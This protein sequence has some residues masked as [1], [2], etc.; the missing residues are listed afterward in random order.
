MHREDFRIFQ[1]EESFYEEFESQVESR[2]VDYIVAVVQDEIESAQALYLRPEEYLQN[3]LSELPTRARLAKLNNESVTI[4]YLSALEQLEHDNPEF[5]AELDP[6]GDASAKFTAKQVKHLTKMLLLAADPASW[7]SM[8]YE[9]VSVVVRENN[10]R[11]LLRRVTWFQPDL[12]NIWVMCE[13]DSLG[14]ARPVLVEKTNN[15]VY[16]VSRATSEKASEMPRIQ[17]AIAKCKSRTRVWDNKP[18]LDEI[19]VD[20]YR[21]CILKT[22]AQ[23]LPAYQAMK[24]KSRNSSHLKGWLAQK[25]RKTYVACLMSGFCANHKCELSEAARR[26]ET[27][28]RMFKSSCIVAEFG[29]PKRSVV[30]TYDAHRKS[31][32]RHLDVLQ[33]KAAK[34]VRK[35][36]QK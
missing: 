25:V 36:F 16:A 29:M 8:E 23:V 32:D 5:Y 2:D 15:K 6:E 30:A 4:A 17:E 10:S 14:R 3:E 11:K 12:D 27:N 26:F 31:Y 21:E 33:M 22:V 1:D 19:S 35:R 13:T 34:C 18:E 9:Q 7:D 20:T 28:L 24:P